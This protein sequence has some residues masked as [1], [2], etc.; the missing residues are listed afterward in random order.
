MSKKVASAYLAIPQQWERPC[1][2]DFWSPDCGRRECSS[3][4]R[5]PGIGYRKKILTV[6]L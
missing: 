2:D 6:L 1:G 5:F 3:F 4:P